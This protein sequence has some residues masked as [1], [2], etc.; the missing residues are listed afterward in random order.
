MA[1]IAVIC[2]IALGTSLGAWLTTLAR[3]AS[4]AISVAAEKATK[5][6]GK[7]VNSK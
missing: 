3:S 2:V 1:T 6:Q 4:Y 7:T 5:A